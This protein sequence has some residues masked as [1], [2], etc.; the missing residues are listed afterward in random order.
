MLKI[1]AELFS[2]CSEE[3]ALGGASDRAKVEAGSA[4]FDFR[5]VAAGSRCDIVGSPALD[6]DRD[7]GQ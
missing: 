5:P 7:T 1:R 2:T 6:I 4:L 3:K